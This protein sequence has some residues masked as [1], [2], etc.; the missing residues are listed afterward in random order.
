VLKVLDEGVGA[1][2]DL[3]YV[4]IL[5]AHHVGRRAIVTE[6]FQNLPIT[7]RLAQAMSPDDEAI[8]RTG[9]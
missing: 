2:E 8:T 7:L 5:P 4:A 1:W 6:H 3:D 9:S